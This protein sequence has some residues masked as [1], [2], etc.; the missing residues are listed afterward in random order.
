MRAAAR[1]Y[2]FCHA[3]PCTLRRRTFRGYD[4]CPCGAFAGSPPLPCSR[5]EVS[6]VESVIRMTLFYAGILPHGP[7]HAAV[8]HMDGEARSGLQVFC[9]IPPYDVHERDACHGTYPGL[10]SVERAALPAANVVHGE[11]P[12]C[13]PSKQAPVPVEHCVPQDVQPAAGP[14]LAVRPAGYG[15][16]LSIAVSR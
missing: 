16:S 9:N 4:C 11:G 13:A 5:M 15:P 6:H 12:F 8:R 2:P 3:H 1:S 7:G 14:C 10:P